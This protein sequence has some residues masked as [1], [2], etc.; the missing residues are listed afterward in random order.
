[1]DSSQVQVATLVVSALLFLCA[2]AVVVAFLR[3]R[4]AADDWRTAE[5]TVSRAWTNRDQGTTFHGVNYS[6]AT[7]E[8]GTFEGEG[9]TADLHEPNDVIE[10]WYDP[11]DPSRNKPELSD[12][13]VWYLVGIPVVLLFIALGVLSLLDGLAIVDLS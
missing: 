9:A 6:F 2:A 11:D 5:A 13:R 12:I 7:P 8:A 10:I 1:M 4:R 3:R